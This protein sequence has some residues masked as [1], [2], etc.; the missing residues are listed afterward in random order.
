LAQLSD[1][2]SYRGVRLKTADGSADDTGPRADNSHR[3]FLGATQL[4]WLKQTLLDAQNNGTTW[5]FVSVSDP[6]D[7]LGP[8]GGSLSGVTAAAMAP[9]LDLALVSK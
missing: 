1:S 8:I 9:L 3:T 7:Q 5:K 6:I 2:R 4:A